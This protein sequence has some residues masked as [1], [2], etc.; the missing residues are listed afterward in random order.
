M[1]SE[2]PDTEMERRLRRIEGMVERLSD[3]QR[4]QVRTDYERRYK[5]KESRAAQPEET[6]V[7]A[8]E[9]SSSDSE[10]EYGEW[11]EQDGQK[12]GRKET[13]SNKDHTSAKVN[14]S[15]HSKSLW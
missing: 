11:T 3:V 4:V 10:S 8:Q 14:Q 7:K 9:S 2:F 6:Q 5:N 13:P 12:K 1:E 15:R